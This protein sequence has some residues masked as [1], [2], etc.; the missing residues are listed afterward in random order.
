MK[1]IFILWFSLL[2]F[3]GVSFWTYTNT[4]S[5][6]QTPVHNQ[7]LNFQASYQNGEV[8]MTWNKFTPNSSNW[9]YYKVVR[10]TNMQQPY[11]PDHWYIKA[12]GDNNTTSYKDSNPPAGTV[13]YGVCAI[14]QNNAW[15]YRNCDWQSVSIDG[16]VTPTVTVEKPEPMPVVSGLSDAL[17]SAVDS[18]IEKLMTNLDDKFGDD[19]AQKITLLETLS[20]KLSTTSVSYKVKPLITYLV[21]KL[22]ETISLLQIELLLDID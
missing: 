12:I 6:W 4:S 14:T 3:V 20:D 21:N 9:Q 7:W 2:I 5:E 16:T 15:R 18:L 1:K 17:K 22:D 13:Y 19:L 8:N 11:Y 10:S